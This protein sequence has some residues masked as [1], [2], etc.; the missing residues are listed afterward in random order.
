VVQ[1]FQ[2]G[3]QEV[4]E[5]QDVPEAVE[6]VAEKSDICGEVARAN[7]AEL[8]Q[9]QMSSDRDAGP[10]ES[11]G[12]SLLGAWPAESDHTVI[13]GRLYPDQSIEICGRPEDLVALGIT[14]SVRQEELGEL[15]E[16]ASYA[17]ELSPAG[18]PNQELDLL[19]VRR[20]DGTI[21]DAVMMPDGSPRP[22]N[23][24]VQGEAVPSGG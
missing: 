19:G 13:Y 7:D 22:L 4:P 10:A 17:Y 20:E 23:A 8:R 24:A 2:S 16:G 5:A 21:F 9:G 3:D 1:L 12:Y 14:S 11:E 15:P 6:T 18:S